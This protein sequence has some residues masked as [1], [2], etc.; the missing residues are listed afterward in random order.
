M[1]KLEQSTQVEYWKRYAARYPTALLDAAARGQI[2]LLRRFISADTDLDLPGTNNTTAL[3]E[4]VRGRHESCVRILIE[5][6]ASVNVVDFSGKTPLSYAR[7]VGDTA[8]VQYLLDNHAG[9]QPT[10]SVL[11]GHKGCVRDVIFSKDGQFILSEAVDGTLR[12]W[13]VDTGLTRVTTPKSEL[14]AVWTGDCNAAVAVLMSEDSDNIPLTGDVLLVQGA[15]W[16]YMCHWHQVNFRFPSS[17]DNAIAIFPMISQI[18]C[19]HGSTVYCWTTSLRRPCHDQDAQDR[20]PDNNTVY[21]LGSPIIADHESCKDDTGDVNI[22]F[23][24]REQHPLD[25][26]SLEVMVVSPDGNLL[27]TIPKRVSQ[28]QNIQCLDIWRLSVVEHSPDKRQADLLFS[29]KRLSEPRHMVFSADSKRVAILSSWDT[30]TIFDILSGSKTHE[31]AMRHAY[32]VHVPQR[33]SRATN[34]A[35]AFSRNGRL[36]AS[37]CTDYTIRL[38]EV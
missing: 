31:F 21:S 37:A 33:F 18:A 11:K 19:T 23:V 13:D 38:F 17:Q 26:K 28:V 29:A 9:L 15:L 8:V 25:A 20:L 4:A 27:A 2:D 3:H 1:P 10:K 7:D 22:H 36:L 12:L 30:V 16:P 35:L 32:T 24:T 14:E 5:H 34:T 6:G